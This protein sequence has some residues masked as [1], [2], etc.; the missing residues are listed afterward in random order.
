MCGVS[1]HRPEVSYLD[2]TLTTH[3]LLLFVMRSDELTVSEIKSYKLTNIYPLSNKM[4]L[5]SEKKI[6]VIK[7]ECMPTVYRNLPDLISEIYVNK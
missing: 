5:L 2:S 6:F 7:N 1:L 3:R 4:I